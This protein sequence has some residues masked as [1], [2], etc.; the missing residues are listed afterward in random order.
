MV[1]RSR[2][3]VVKLAIHCLPAGMV[4]VGIG[5]PTCPELSVEVVFCAELVRFGWDGVWYG[6]RAGTLIPTVEW[7]GEV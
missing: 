3:W 2:S 5:V 7:F 4:K 1:E 6:G